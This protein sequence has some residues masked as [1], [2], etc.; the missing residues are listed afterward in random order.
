MVRAINE[1]G[2]ADLARE[3]I[4]CAHYPLGHRRYQQC[5]VCPSCIFRRQAMIVGGIDE[6]QGSYSFDLFGTAEAA[7]VVPQEKLKYLKAFLMQVARWDDIEKTG[8]LPESVSRHLL[9]THILKVGESPEAI[10]DLLVRHRDEWKQIVAKGRR[11]RISVG[12]A[13]RP[14]PDLSGTRSQPC[15]RLK[16]IHEFWASGSPRPARPVARRRR[17]SP[18]SLACSRPTYIAIEKG[19]RAAKPDEII[20]LASFFGRKVNELVRP[21]EPVTDLQP[22]LRAVADKMKSGDQNQVA[23]T[24]PSTSFSRSPRTTGSLSGS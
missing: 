2:L 3:T 11:A 12:E 19:D 23:S 4:S 13:A 6:P 9:E 21:G 7:N 8:R 16:S 24:P 18:N 17:R 14:G 20:K 22:H 10:I 5:G 15:L 1:A